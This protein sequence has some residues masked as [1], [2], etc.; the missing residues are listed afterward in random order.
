M[1][2]NIKLIRKCQYCGKQFIAKTT[3]TKNCSDNCAKRAYKQKLKERKIYAS[4]IEVASNFYV[5]KNS[6]HEKPYLS[7]GEASTLFG[8][9]EKTIRRMINSKIIP[10][11]RL[12]RRVVIISEEFKEFLKIF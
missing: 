1:S 4:E 2:S 7:V 3:V 12:N 8:V 6:L 10:I 9:S 5:K 11:L